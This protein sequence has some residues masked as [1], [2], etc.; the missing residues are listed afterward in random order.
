MP[1]NNAWNSTNPAQVS[2]GGTGRSSVDAYTVV[3]GGTTNINPLQNV[4]G[5]GNA[6]DILTSN[7]PA[8]LPSWQPGCGTGRYSFLIEPLHQAN[9]TGDG[10]DY[11]IIFDQVSV[12]HGGVWD[13][14]NSQFVTPVRG[15]YFFNY[16]VEFYG[17]PSVTPNPAAIYE[18]YL[19]GPVTQRTIWRSANIV[20]SIGETLELN[21]CL[22]LNIGDIVYP[23]I[24]ITGYAP[25]SFG[26]TGLG[27]FPWTFISGYLVTIV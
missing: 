20:V 15:L 2:K 27:D 14:V 9:V 24:K 19:H 12:N 25:N 7:G 1:T 10:T 17:A 23:S 11:H 6:G 3:C 22:L 16:H 8:A 13:T 21:T 26:V 18:I 4:V 5:T